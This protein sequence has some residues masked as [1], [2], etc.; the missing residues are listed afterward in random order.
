M[1]VCFCNCLFVC[2]RLGVCIFVRFFLYTSSSSFGRHWCPRNWRKHVTDIEA[3]LHRQRLRWP[4]HVILLKTTE[5]QR[6]CSTAI[7]SMFLAS[8]IN[9]E[10]AARD[11]IKLLQ[12][13]SRR[14]WVLETTLCDANKW[15]HVIHKGELLGIR[16]VLGKYQESSNLHMM[17]V[18][19]YIPQMQSWLV[20]RRVK[21]IDVWQILI[22]AIMQITE[23]LRWIKRRPTDTAS[24]FPRHVKSC[25]QRVMNL[26]SR[27]SS[28]HPKITN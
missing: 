3:H 6:K 10:S 1:C 5:Y 2:V 21:L 4:G 23:H 28:L 15:K 18:T 7:G 14:S 24:V 25:D 19:H 11:C 8:S 16:I 9:Q 17:N 26:Q 27:P 13:P 20:N 22:N 12:L